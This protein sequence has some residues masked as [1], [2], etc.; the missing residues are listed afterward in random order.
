M[1]KCTQIVHFSEQ[2]N[3]KFRLCS[4]EWRKI[5]RLLMKSNG[6]EENFLERGKFSCGIT[7]IKLKLIDHI[8]VIVAQEERQ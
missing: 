2:F 4:I 8:A 7:D 1:S 3:G 6:I 5:I